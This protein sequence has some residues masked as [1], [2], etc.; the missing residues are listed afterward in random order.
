MEETVTPS[1]NNTIKG[2]VNMDSQVKR[3]TQSQVWKGVD[4]IIQKSVKSCLS[5]VMIEREAALA[6]GWDVQTIILTSVASPLRRNVVRIVRM[7]ST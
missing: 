1:V 6:K 7:D 4:G 5:M 3:G 2:D